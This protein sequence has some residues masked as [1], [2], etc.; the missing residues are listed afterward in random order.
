MNAPTLE[1]HLETVDAALP[2]QP[3]SYDLKQLVEL[4]LD[5]DGI[6]IRDRQ[7]YLRHYRSCFVG[8]EL[9]TFLS[10]RLAIPRQSALELAQRLE[11]GGFIRHVV[12][13]HPIRDEHLF[14]RINRALPAPLESGKLDRQQLAEIVQAMR[15]P[16]GIPFGVRYRWFVRYPNCFTGKEAV[17]WISSYCEV[18]RDEAV[19]IGQ[20]LLRGNYIRHLFDEHD[21]SDAPLLY[22]FV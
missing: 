10:E 15:T 20:S 6:D 1:R 18:P 9:I 21:F 19:K 17:D 4:L 3:E 2:G 14:Y 13:V 16:G 5:D 12:G 7:Y 8:S 11:A 22:R